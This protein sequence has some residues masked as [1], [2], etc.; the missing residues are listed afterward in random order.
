MLYEL[1]I[2]GGLESLLAGS[3]VRRLQS[4]R[5]EGLGGSTRPE[6]E[7]I[8]RLEHL[9]GTDALEGLVHGTGSDGGLMILETPEELRDQPGGGEGPGGVVNHHD[10][11]RD[12]A[13][14]GPNGCLARRAAGYADGGG[15]QQRSGRS[16]VLL[17][18]HHN[19]RIAARLGQKVEAPTDQ[20]T[21]V[22]IEELLGRVGR[23]AGTG[24]LT[25]ASGGEDRCR[26]RIEVRYPRTSSSIFSAASSSQFFEK[27]N[28]ETRICRALVSIRFSPAAKPF[29]L[30]R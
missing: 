5:P 14:A 3:L 26:R 4:L 11:R 29:S 20:G 27:V 13:Q 2:V 30:S 15:L 8:H 17:G 10:L 22:E 16:Y 21:A 28:S 25:G 18:N 1:G 9:I 7:T 19:D 24:S 12:P 23:R 6:R